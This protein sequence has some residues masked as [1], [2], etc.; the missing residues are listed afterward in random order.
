MKHVKFHRLFTF[1]AAAILLTSAGAASAQITA[2]DDAYHY[3]KTNWYVA[4]PTN[5]GYGFTPWAYFTNGPSSHG[6]FTTHNVGTAPNPTISSPTNS[7]SPPGNDNAQ[8]VWGMFANGTGANMTVVYRGFSNSLTTSVV[9]KMQWQND[10]IG[11]SSGNSGGFVLRNGNSTNGQTSDYRT[12]QRFSFYYIGGGSDSFSYWDNNG[13]NYINLPFTTAGLECEFTLEP[14]G[15]YRF[16]VKNATNDTILALLD[17]QPLIPAG[18]GTID[19]VALFSQETSKNQEFNRMQIVSASLT[20]PSILN[21]QPTNGLSSY[22]DP[23]VQNVSFEVGTTATTVSSNGITLTL[24]GVLQSNLLFN[25][26]GATNDLFVTNNTPLQANQVYS[27]VIVAT[28][29]NGNRATNTLAF[30]TFLQSNPFI[31]AED[32]NYGG[33]SYISVFPDTDAAYLNLTGE[34]GI[35]YHEPDTSIVNNAYRPSDTTQLLNSNDTID[36][37]GYVQAGYPDYYLG[38]IETGEWEDYT[39]ELPT[40]T[41]TVYARV[42]GFGT[43][44]VMELERLAGPTASSS[45]QPLAAIGQFAIPSTGGSANYT[46][47]PLTDFFGRTVLVNSPGVT[48]FRCTAVGGSRAYNFNYL[49]LVPNTN[50]ATIHPYISAGSPAG[51]ATGVAL[52]S[53]ITFTIAN[54]GASVTPGSIQLL[55]NSVDTTS[56][57]TIDNNAAGASVTYS[58]PGWLA[59]NTVYSVS[60][61]YTDSASVKAT[62]TW[63]FTSANVNVAVIPPADAQPV[64]AGVTNGFS[65]L[66]YKVDDSAPTTASI[67][68]AEVELVGGRID[69]D[70]SA[71]YP[72]LAAGPNGDGSYVEIGAINYDITAA[73]TGTPTF[74]YKNAFPNVAPSAVNN[75]IAMQALTYVELTPGSYHFAVRS[76]DGFKLTAG[77]TATDTNLVLG[78]FDGGRGNGSPSDIYFSVSAAGLYPMRLLYYQAGSGGNVEFYSIMNGA[79]V[80]INDPTNSA[81]IKTFA[82]LNSVTPPAAVTIANPAYS[83]GTMTFSFT[84]QANH[85]NYVEYKNTLSDPTWIPLRAVSGSGSVTNISDSTASGA[86]RFYRVRTQ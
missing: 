85:T 51:G 20:P 61:I 55:V 76:D 16:V 38:Y 10:G 77:P 75:N 12:G 45:T 4:T 60:V 6:L 28:D 26:T 71:P 78:Q 84:T 35:D 23:T 63:Q 36:H 47:V 18:G 46:L 1:A 52:D 7:S 11:V 49:T 8:H 32:Y 69:P 54:G 72:N 13:P 65:L 74:P 17:G 73:P 48:T 62:N 57:A 42:A 22:I 50:T 80:L 31:E 27:A 64:S 53:P 21:V 33:G 34:E 2:Y 25:T 14:G 5:L 24:N 56:S 19:S 29:S 67:S 30:N 70:T 59:P 40:Q 37:A 43:S 9:F 58:P 81:S 39:R 86:T 66:L 83:A 15:T 44:P 68:N 3:T 82:F 41:Y 79:P